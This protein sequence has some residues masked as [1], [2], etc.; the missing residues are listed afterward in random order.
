M[1]AKRFVEVFEARRRST[2]CPFGGRAEGLTGMPW[3]LN[4]WMEKMIEG[5]NSF[6]STSRETFP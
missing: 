6:W 1:L 5:R 2:D 3:Q 4:V